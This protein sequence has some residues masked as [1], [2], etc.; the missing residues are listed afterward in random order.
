[1]INKM[2]SKVNHALEKNTNRISI[3]IRM[4][5]IYVKNNNAIL[6]RRSLKKS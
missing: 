3:E 6:K 1:M 4:K 2:A 5:I